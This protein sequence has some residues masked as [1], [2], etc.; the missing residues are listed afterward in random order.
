MGFNI[1]PP[2]GHTLILDQHIG[3]FPIT[4]CVHQFNEWAVNKLHFEGFQS[5]KCENKQTKVENKI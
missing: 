1:E 3:T 2:K 5:R 4:G